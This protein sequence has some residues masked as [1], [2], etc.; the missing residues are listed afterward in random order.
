MSTS[1]THIAPDQVDPLPATEDGDRRPESSPNRAFSGAEIAFLV[2]VPL[3]WAVLLLFHPSGDA[4]RMYADTHDKVTPWLAVHIGM[5]FF[6]PL[7]AAVGYLLLRGVEGTA[8]RVS[9][10]ALLPFAVFYATWEALQGIAIGVL[11]DRVN[12]LPAAER[13]TGA[14]LVQGFGENILIRDL[15]LLGAPGS[16]A[17]VIAMIAAGVALRRHAGAPLAVPVLLGLAGFLITAHPP[18]FGPTGL[19]VFVAAV[20]LLVRS[21]AAK[22]PTDPVLQPAAV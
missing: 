9:R 7:M 17:F 14:D 18:P 15:G 3:L 13:A 21:Q 4:N 20:V 19:V 12:D 5:M 1:G 8:A 6:I 2:V 10:I 16:V 11:I 22:R